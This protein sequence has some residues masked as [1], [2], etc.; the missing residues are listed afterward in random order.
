MI[1]LVWSGVLLGGLLL[2]GGVLQPSAR[3]PR[4]RTWRSPGLSVGLA[5]ASAAI[6]QLV[7]GI[8]VAAVIAGVAGGAIPEFLRRRRESSTKSALAS[9]WP[10][11]LDDVTSAVRA[12]MNLPEALVQAGR[13][14]PAQIAVHFSVF[15]REYARTGDF[16]TCAERLR[17][18]IGDAVFDELMRSLRIAR[19]VGG[20]DL[21]Q[22]LRSLSSFLRADLQIRGELRAR[23][24]WTVNSARLAVSAPWA[25]LLLLSSRPSTLV[26]Y[27]SVEGSTVLAGIALCSVVAYSAMLRIARVDGAR[28]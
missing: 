13:R 8:L 14:Q 2:F 26:A 16:F 24:S 11:L 25:V 22:V 9:Q 12:G 10:V 6:T 7:V 27:S 3:V 15:E 18:D 28:L 4:S 17:A 19:Q 1:A 23:Q 20:T 21:T 5:I